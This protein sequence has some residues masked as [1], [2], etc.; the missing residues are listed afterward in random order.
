MDIVGGVYKLNH[1]GLLV[2]VTPTMA[3]LMEL[4]KMILLEFEVL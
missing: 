3:E 4:I 2:L 1:D